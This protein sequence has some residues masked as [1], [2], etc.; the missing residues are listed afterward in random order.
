MIESYMIDFLDQLIDEMYQK[1]NYC[2]GMYHICTHI[3]NPKIQQYM[4]S[5]WKNQFKSLLMHL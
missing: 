5:E 1:Y 3:S 4:I 2:E